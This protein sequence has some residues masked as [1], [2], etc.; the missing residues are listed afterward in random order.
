M[1]YLRVLPVLLVAAG[2]ASAQP[3]ISQTQFGFPSA[4]G[5]L[6]RNGSWLPARCQIKAG[7][8]SVSDGAFLLELETTDGE[9]AAYQLHFPIPAIA[10]GKTA[11]VTGYLRP[12]SAASIFHARVMT[13]EGRL[14]KSWPAPRR[15]E[16]QMAGPRDYLIATAGS[17]FEGLKKAARA[18][19]A[20]TDSTAK[21]GE[22]AG[23]NSQRGPR[24][25]S[26]LNH[27]NELPEHPLGFD[28]LDFL[29]INSGSDFARLLLE[30][31]MRERRLALSA[32]LRQGGKLLLDTG[33]HSSRASEILQALGISGCD[34]RLH[35]Q[36]ENLR[37]LNGLNRWVT[38]LSGQQLPLR[39]KELGVLSPG[40]NAQALVQEL[41]EPSDPVLRPIL[42]QIPF[43]RGRVLVSALELDAEPFL[44]WGGQQG[45]WDKLLLGLAPRNP[46]FAPGKFPP[47]TAVAR[48][49]TAAE[50]QRALETYPQIPAF[51]FGWVALLILG[52]ILIVGPIDFLL[53]Q[54]WLKRP[55]LTWVTFPLVVFLAS[56][57]AWSAAASIKG[58]Q[59]RINKVDLV[60]FDSVS[61]TFQGT[62]WMAVFSPAPSEN[63]LRLQSQWNQGSELLPP[64]IMVL[65]PPDRAFRGGSRTLYRRPY[66]YRGL[67]QEVASFGIPAW[68]CASFHG[69]WLRQTEQDNPPFSSR[70][71]HSRIDG[72]LVTGT[73]SNNL[74][75]D[76][77]DAAL[78]YQESWFPLGAFQAGETRRI[79]MV[80]AGGRGQ[81]LQQWF[82]AKVLSSASQVEGN[83]RGRDLPAYRL[84]KA[85]AFHAH[86][87]AADPLYNSGWR[88]LDLGWRLRPV[89]ETLLA[90]QTRIRHAEEILLVGRLAKN[91]APPSR[92]L[93]VSPGQ[94]ESNAAIVQESFVRAFFPIGSARP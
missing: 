55:E 24:R 20:A 88:P 50:L 72:N 51:T 70:L 25:F 17:S 5:N 58:S 63:S 66:E 85:L 28:S 34:M 83:N 82:D 76:L 65:D 43:G 48:N 53:T 41:P 12:G 36:T 47:D 21:Q 42:V 15:E 1:F 40:F 75:A 79:D 73:I 94:I 64:Q 35:T 37:A 84:V 56:W 60:D 38:P 26:F 91:A 81:S 78:F 87:E 32:W 39:I 6:T 16:G 27:P 18:S 86:P 2:V 67:A 9:G 33:K 13:K 14:V 29:V 45:Y 23:G 71:I 80:Q 8:R 49:E 10:A 77:E 61:G 52:Y 89:A 44:S 92:L 59:A 69:Q 30:P 11:E 19:Q 3:E 22:M 57:G 68:A 31:E 54:K 4:A 90:G 74:P 46:G 62:A 7:A 93:L